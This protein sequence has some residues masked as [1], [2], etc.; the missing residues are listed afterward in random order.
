MALKS[1]WAATAAVVA[2]SSPALSSPAL[3]QQQAQANQ[4]AQAIGLE[5]IVVTAQRRETRLQDTPVAVTALSA[6][7]IERGQFTE[8]LD[9]G[10]I[11]PNLIAINNVTLGASN[12][13]FL[14]GIG[15]TESIATF[16]PPVGT[17]VDDVFVA[18][19]NANNI[20]LFEVERIEVLRGPQGTLF[21]RNTTGGAISIITK[22]PSEEF[23]AKVEASYGRFDEIRTKGSLNIPLSDKVYTGVSAYYVKDDGWQESVRTGEKYNFID[24]YGVRGAVRVVPSDN[25]TWDFSGDWQTQDHQNLASIVDPARAATNIKAGKSGPWVLGTGRK[26]DVYLRNCKTGAGPLQWVRNGCTAN[27]V[28]GYNLYS[29]IA[30]DV[31]ESLSF[32]IITGYRNLD[33]DFVSPLFASLRAGFELPLS[34]AGNHNQF[35]NEIKLNGELADGALRYTTGL[36]YMKEDNL[37]RY[38]TSLAAPPANVFLVLDDSNL[39][40][41]TESFAWYAQAEYDIDK[42]TL[43]AGVRWTDEKKTIKSFTHGG[44]NG[45]FNLGNVIAA[46]I[47]NAVSAVVWTPKGVIQYNVN[48]DVMFYVSATRG[49]KSG[50]WNARASAADRLTRF[51]EETVWSYEIGTRAEF[52]DN[53]V[54]TNITGFSATYS[55]LQLPALLRTPGVG[56]APIFVTDNAGKSRVRGVEFEGTALITEG[57]TGTLTFGIQKGKYLELGPR[58]TAGGFSLD[59][60]TDR[61]PDFT[62]NVGLTYETPINMGGSVVLTADYQHVSDFAGNGQNNP[63]NENPGFD[64]VNASVG[65]TSEDERWGVSL[66][67]KNCT[68]ERIIGTHFLNARF[69]QDPLRWSLRFTYN[70][71]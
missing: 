47:P 7:Q 24:A 59:D 54:R 33:H 31:G 48:D 1:K 35:S 36:F 30:V 20:E 2:F 27:E 67:C 34:N 32:N 18:R 69:L 52:M 44:A 66:G 70:Y 15:S 9:L 51:N 71:N 38:E 65:W 29:N 41:D 46:G 3:A 68:D 37:T 43:I 22:K 61:T 5:E 49:F 23:S 57:L 56:E 21:G 53:R 62:S 58:V 6:L 10:R 14:R 4:E 55:D 19:Q 16:D 63:E 42:L 17:Y 45:V 12:T 60:E 11:V 40:N 39:E 64:T 26:N 8:S 13:Y 25:V 28:T 50:G